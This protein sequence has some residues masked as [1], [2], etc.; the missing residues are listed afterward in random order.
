MRALGAGA[1]ASP[2]VA[3]VRFVIA[4]PVWQRV[5]FLALGGAIA[6]AMAYGIHRLRLARLIALEQVRTRIATDLHDDIGS[7][8]TRIAILAEGARRRHKA[9][10]P[11][12]SGV[13]GAIASAS[14]DLIDTT[15]DIVW[16]VNPRHDSLGDL[17]HRMRRFAEETLEEAGFSLTFS[18]PDDDGELKLVS[19]V[20]RE[21]YLVC[22]ETITNI[23][24]HAGASAAAVDL[25]VDGHRLRLTISDTGR[26]FD[27]DAPTDGTGLSSLR[28]RAAAIGG[29]IVVASSPGRGTRV[30]LDV[31]LG[32]HRR[33]SS[34]R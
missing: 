26:G 8:L 32:R 14:R 4:R 12:M 16:A 25:R 1:T 3:G 24:K 30:T 17:T 9:R 19:D 7:G 31:D 28:R 20:R 29:T 27:P 5:P 23:A 13:L 6:L 22:K 21:I 34:E 15:S 10:D 33:A 11:G 2:E 18:A